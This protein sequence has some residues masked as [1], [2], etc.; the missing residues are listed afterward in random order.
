[1]KFRN[2]LKNINK[3]F[4]KQRRKIKITERKAS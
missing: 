2:V 4:S 1:L 3:M